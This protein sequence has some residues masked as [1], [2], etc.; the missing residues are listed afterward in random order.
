[1]LVTLNELRAI[2]KDEVERNM[3]W[4]AGF[5]GGG[6]GNAT[7]R[8]A[9]EPP[10]GLGDEDGEPDRETWRDRHAEG[11]PEQ[12]TPYLNRRKKRR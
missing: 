2:I 1:M 6:G 8:G 5:Y 3:R 4:L 10:P 7:G 12:L 9:A 11:P